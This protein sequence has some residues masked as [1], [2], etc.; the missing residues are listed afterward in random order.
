MDDPAD[1][2]D[3]GSEDGDSFFGFDSDESC[4]SIR[5]HMRRRWRLPEAEHKPKA[6]FELSPGVIRETDDY[7]LAIVRM[8]DIPDVIKDQ[9][10]M[11]QDFYTAWKKHKFRFRK[12]SEDAGTSKVFNF[13]KNR[14]LTEMGLENCEILPSL[15]DDFTSLYSQL[16]NAFLLF[17]NAYSKHAPTCYKMAEFCFKMATLASRILTALWKLVHGFTLSS[18]ANAI[19][20]TEFPVTNILLSFYGVFL[21][22]LNLYTEY[23]K[24]VTTKKSFEQDEEFQIGYEQRPIETQISA[25]TSVVDVDS[26]KLG[27]IIQEIVKFV[28]RPTD[29]PKQEEVAAQDASE[30]GMEVGEYDEHDPLSRVLT[31]VAVF[32][33]DMR[34]LCHQLNSFLIRES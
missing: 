19:K 13:W 10:R 23:V 34:S 9:R 6:P 14:T 24:Y 30:E 15:I 1:V 25:F 5:D 17:A 7:K 4:T 8:Q 28:E 2:T 20:K 21:C 27:K 31:Y 22:F 12:E 3:P 26:E 11:L 33:D 32:V 16:S 18:K 29:P